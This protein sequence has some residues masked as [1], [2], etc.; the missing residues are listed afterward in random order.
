MIP[1]VTRFALVLADRKLSYESKD[2]LIAKVVQAIG[3]TTTRHIRPQ[4]IQQRHI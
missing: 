2:I 4:T 3:T 1:L